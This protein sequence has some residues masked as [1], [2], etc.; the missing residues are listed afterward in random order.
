M[1]K[2]RKLLKKP[3]N[4]IEMTAAVLVLPAATVTT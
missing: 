2:A 3:T 4:L 1:K